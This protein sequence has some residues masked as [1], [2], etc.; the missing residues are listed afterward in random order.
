MAMTFYYLSGSPFSWKVWLALERKQLAYDLRILS[1]DAGDLKTAEFVAINPRGKVPAI[2]DDGFVLYESAAII[3]YLQDNYPQS[4]QPLW[5]HAVRARALARRIAGEADSY[6]YPSV[7]KLV[8]EL[9]ARRE[10]QPDAAIIEEA[11]AALVGEFALLERSLLGPFVTGSDPSAADFAH[12][13]LAAIIRRIEA[14]QPHYEVGDVL[15]D[16]I[17]KWM[18]Q[19]GMLPY[20]AKTTPPH[21]RPQ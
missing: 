2:V 6:I 11:K 19:I 17:R 1:S 15:P 9:I 21:W 16:G 14:R 18:E 5:P 13:P 20:F 4:G 10:G 7:R 3:E 8:L 12:Y